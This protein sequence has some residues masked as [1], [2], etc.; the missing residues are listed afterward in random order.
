MLDLSLFHRI[1][2]ILMFLFL[3]ALVYHFVQNYSFNFLFFHISNK[4]NQFFIDPCF[5]FL[6]FP[7]RHL[8][9]C[10]FL[11]YMPAALHEKNVWFLLHPAKANFF[12]TKKGTPKWSSFP[13]IV[14]QT[15]IVHD[16]L[17]PI[18]SPLRNLAATYRWV[19]SRTKNIQVACRK[20]IKVVVVY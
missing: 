5:L 8:Y 6:H 1:S 10:V 2:L 3:L 7:V 11:L 17:N 9:F 18:Q 12:C 20:T 13:Y 14:I 15:P 19:V 16:S 4:L